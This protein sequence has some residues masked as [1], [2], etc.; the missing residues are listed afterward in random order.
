MTLHPLCIVCGGE[1]DRPGM[2]CTT[3][4]N[5]ARDVARVDAALKRQGGPLPMALVGEPIEVTGRRMREQGTWPAE[6]PVPVNVHDSMP[7][8]QPGRV[9]RGSERTRQIAARW[10]P[11]NSHRDAA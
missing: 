4:R 1:K 2:R 11:V 5:P 3:C 9:R 6:W 10:R 7:T 8:P